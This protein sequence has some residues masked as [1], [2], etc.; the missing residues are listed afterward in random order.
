M[1]THGLEI[2]K[3]SD[4]PGAVLPQ[5]NAKDRRSFYKD[6]ISLI[7]PGFL[8][9]QVDVRGVP[10]SIRTLSGYELAL[11]GQRVGLRATQIDWKVW[12]VASS[13]WMFEGR[14][15]LSSKGLVPLVKE[16]VE[17]FPILI[18]QRLWLNWVALLDRQR[19]AAIAVEAFCYEK[20][21][22]FIWHTVNGQPLNS[23][24]MTGIRGTS[25]LGLNSVQHIWTVINHYEDKREEFLREWSCAKL[26]ASSNSPKGM[27]RIDAKDKLEKQRE[28]KRRQSVLDRFY[29][30]AVGL[31]GDDDKTQE[32][33]RIASRAM[34]DQEL[35]ESYRRWVE[36]DHD[37]HDKVILMHKQAV[38]RRYEEQE[39]RHQKRMKE[40]ADLPVENIEMRPLIG[41][42]PEQVQR[43][44]AD[45]G[46]GSPGVRKVE[47]EGSEGHIYDKYYRGEKFEVKE[48][49]QDLM[50][51]ITGRRVTEDTLNR[52]HHS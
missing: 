10:F 13:I 19:A 23:Q 43:I 2:L 35:Q 51:Q 6:V 3:Q 14:N 49:P 9:L 18:L 32:G 7:N 33:M 44:M 27:K 29:Y 45:Q 26:V 21:S 25:S 22:R 46:R 36:N 31:L 41:Y 5:S 37:W 34:T 16:A 28:E 40:L 30:R 4:L 17:S 38:K 39:L 11:L 52:H 15:L 1:T 48:S 12:T 47:G 24:S 50:A 42:T 20:E 8:S